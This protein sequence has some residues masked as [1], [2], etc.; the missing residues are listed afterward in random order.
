MGAVN[1]TQRVN[2]RS[3]VLCPRDLR[4]AGRPDAEQVVHFE[5]PERPRVGPDDTPIVFATGGFSMTMSTNRTGKRWTGA[6]LLALCLACSLVTSFGAA[7]AA[8]PEV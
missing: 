6:W 4:A 8:K 5:L 3:G 1:R 7:S 2:P